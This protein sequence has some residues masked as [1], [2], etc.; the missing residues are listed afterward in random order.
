MKV[1]SP[2]NSPMIRAKKLHTTEWLT[3]EPAATKCIIPG[4][5]SMSVVLKSGIIIAID[6]LVF[7]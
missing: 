2:T 6:R 4:K 1:C 5:S 3:I 7:E